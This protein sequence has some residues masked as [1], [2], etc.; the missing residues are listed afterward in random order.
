MNDHSVR[1]QTE[2]VELCLYLC[3]LKY[4]KNDCYFAFCEQSPYMEFFIQLPTVFNTTAD[5][6]KNK[7]RCDGHSNKEVHAQASCFMYVDF[8]II[9]N[10]MFPNKEP[11]CIADALSCQQTLTLWLVK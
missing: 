4:K 9:I 1:V 6:D 7:Y 5:R 8:V 11:Q 3:S 10:H 2:N